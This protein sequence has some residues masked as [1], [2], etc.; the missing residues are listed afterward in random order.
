MVFTRSPDKAKLFILLEII[1]KKTNKVFYFS[2]IKK[3]FGCFE[4]FLYVA[5][6]T[7]RF[8]IQTTWN[9]TNKYPSLNTM[10]KPKENEP[11]Q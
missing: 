3:G 4:F 10:N 11:L 6:L 2:L 8:N 7:G 5:S 1:Y 9:K